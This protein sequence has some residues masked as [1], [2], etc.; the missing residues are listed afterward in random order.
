MGV[1]IGG[2]VC[3]AGKV[4]AWGGMLVGSGGA[5]TGVLATS[6]TVSPPTGL[7]L[8]RRVTDP[9]KRCVEGVS[10]GEAA[11]KAKIASGSN[12]SNV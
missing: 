2:R 7:T 9:L 5:S 3:S 1:W 6:S 4:C 11:T 10:A 8:A 12:H